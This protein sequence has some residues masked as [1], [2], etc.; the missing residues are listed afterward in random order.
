LFIFIPEAL[1]TNLR[2]PCIS[3]NH[4]TSSLLWPPFPVH[5]VKFIT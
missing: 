3:Y 1:K 5:Y 4:T 2:H